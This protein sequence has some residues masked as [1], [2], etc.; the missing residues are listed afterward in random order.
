MQLRKGLAVFD[1]SDAIQVGFGD[2]AHALT[3][4]T[5]SER[6]LLIL[7][8]KTLPG[9]QVRTR[10]RRLGI[11]DAR[12]QEIEKDLAEADLLQYDDSGRPRPF[13]LHVTIARVSDPRQFHLIRPFLK[14]LLH[15]P[16]LAHCALDITY[17]GED[18]GPHPRDVIASDLDVT[19]R[20]CETPDVAI[21]LFARAPSTPVVMNYVMSHTPLLTV[22][23]G[24]G[25]TEVGPYAHPGMEPCIQCIDMHYGDADEQWE[26]ISAQL[27]DQPFPAVGYSLAR[28]TAHVVSSI[29]DGL[30]GGT[31]PVPGLVH[32]IDENLVSELYRF[33][34]H[35]ECGCGFTPDQWLDGSQ[36]KPELR[37]HRV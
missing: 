26:R 13:A 7:L 35:P 30:R 34:P 24:E 32:A 29:I 18:L 4:L 23:F 8:R 3:G 33:P 16:S 22:V 11:A 21:I 19:L 25:Y 28:V 1:R 15:H 6:A 27:S 37:T 12:M 10:A 9:S 17:L 5:D 36:L 31:I 20:T 14:T 2:H